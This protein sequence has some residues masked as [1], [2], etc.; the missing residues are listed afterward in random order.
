MPST[1]RRFL[2]LVG[3]GTT[4][5][6]G[7]VGG[8]G[9]TA[10]P[11]PD[12]SPTHT[13]SPTPTPTP[14]PEPVVEFTVVRDGFDALDAPAV[15]YPPNLRGWLRTAARRDEPVRAHGTA[16][17]YAPEPL[18]AGV[19]GLTLA[20]EEQDVA[21][22][23]RAE[24]AGGPYYEYLIGAERVDSPP[25]DA[26]VTDL[27]ALAAPTRDL[28]ARAI[29]GNVRVEPQTVAGQWYLGEWIGS[30]YRTDG[31]V[32]RGIEVQQTDAG[33]F[34]TDAYYVLDLSPDESAS[35]PTLDVRPVPGAVRSA[36]DDG[37]A[38]GVEKLPGTSSPSFT[39]G[40][41]LPGAAL[42]FARET[43]YVLTHTTLLSVAVTGEGA[44][45][46]GGDGSRASGRRS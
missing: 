42:S 34:S 15:V 9:G 44:S 11:Q 28:A 3:T 33:F 25:P 19:E 32:Y 13:S 27:D 12:E 46:S 37:L 18:L 6:A 35:G 40:P 14:T 21:G 20:A 41:N 7:C 39:V 1:R 31:R 45:E 4:G 16:S 10:T 2:A 8:S 22:T 24:I 17:Q 30:Y 38:R 26:T 43:D 5:L 23:F 29:D 36:L